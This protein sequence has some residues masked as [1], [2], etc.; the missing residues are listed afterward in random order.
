MPWNKLNVEV[1]EL[2]NENHKILMKELKK[3]QK[4]RHPEFMIWKT[5]Y[6]LTW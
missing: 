3:S 4:R 6:Y 5:Q 2:Y 1:T